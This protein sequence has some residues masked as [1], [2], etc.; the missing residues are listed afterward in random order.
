[1]SLEQRKIAHSC[2][3]T[4]QEQRRPRTSI[5]PA[6]QQGSAKIFIRRSPNLPAHLRRSCMPRN[7]GGCDTAHQPQLHSWGRTSSRRGGRRGGALE[8]SCSQSAGVPCSQHRRVSH[9]PRR[10][11]A[12]AGTLPE[13]FAA[14]L[15]ERP[16]RETAPAHLATA[17]ITHS[18]QHA[19]C[20]A[21]GSM[22]QAACATTSTDPASDTCTDK[23][24][25][26]GCDSTVHP[27]SM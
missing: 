3:G 26:C 23:R 27:D 4:S 12:Q 6:M 14:L 15:L 5:I 9:P 25:P 16:C 22:P 10:N 7:R 2:L 11:H 8:R 17:L 13:R 1:M 18:W 24:D 21:S 20:P 19:P